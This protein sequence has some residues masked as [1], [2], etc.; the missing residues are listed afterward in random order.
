MSDD[1]DNVDSLMRIFGLERRQVYNL[2]E[3]GIIPA[4]VKSV[5]NIPECTIR[6]IRHLKTKHTEAGKVAR[7]TIATEEAAQMQMKTAEMRGELSSR[8]GVKADLEDALT[9]GAMAI[10]NLDSLT[11]AQKEEVLSILRAIKLPPRDE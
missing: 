1:L 6:Y 4:P 5:W 9:K 10:Q 3:D 2:K 11:T 8:A 7:S